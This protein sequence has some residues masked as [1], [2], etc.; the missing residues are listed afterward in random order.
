MAFL[1]V[2]LCT[3]D[4]PGN[5]IRRE[6]DPDEIHVMP[7]VG[8]TTEDDQHSETYS[9]EDD[10]L[11]AGE[12]DEEESSSEEEESAADEESQQPPA[13]YI[14]SSRQLED[15]RSAPA[16]EYTPRSQTV[17]TEQGLVPYD[18]TQSKSNRSRSSRR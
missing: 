4:I 14:S 11:M 16:S 6:R 9:L 5:W 3:I 15:E 7:P 13:S 1:L 2:S 12:V 8:K 18:D 17:V 10:D